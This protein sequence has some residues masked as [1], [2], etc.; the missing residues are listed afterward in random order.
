[1]INAILTLPA[2]STDILGDLFAPKPEEK[3][4]RNDLKGV[5]FG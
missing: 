2:P 5:R 1:V 3:M 4:A